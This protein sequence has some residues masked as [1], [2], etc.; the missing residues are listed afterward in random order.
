MARGKSKKAVVFV[1][2]G[3]TDKD[4]LEHIL[5]VLYKDKQIEFVITS[6]DIT[7]REDV[8]VANVE[9]MLAD[10]VEKVLN[11]DKLTWED[12][13]QVIHIID[14]DGCFI[15][16]DRIAQGDVTR[17]EYSDNGITCPDKSRC[18]ARNEHKRAVVNYLLNQE[19]LGSKHYEMYF[20]SCNIDDALHG[21]K[22]LS[23]EEKEDM[24][25][26]FQDAFLGNEKKFVDYLLQESVNGVPD[27]FTSSWRYIKEGLHSVE[28]H[29]NFHLYFKRNPYDLFA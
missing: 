14:T 25:L 3:Q 28:R 29:T 10:T 18:I 9:N 16:D 22:N 23:V 1:V 11:Y 7:T 8:T 24:S 12:V 17:F 26:A 15:P 4:A 19:T 2:E 13:Y 21:E 6:G 27:S 20:M 5:K